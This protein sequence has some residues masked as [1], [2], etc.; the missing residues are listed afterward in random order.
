MGESSATSE[1]VEADVMIMDSDTGNDDDPGQNEPDEPG[2][3]DN[4]DNGDEPGIKFPMG[5][6]QG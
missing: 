6:K 3:G 4:G 5:P 2:N 1:Y